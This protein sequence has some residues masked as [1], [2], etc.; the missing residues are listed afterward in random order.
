MFSS[1]VLLEPKKGEVFLK[2]D[3]EM[4]GCNHT[5]MKNCVL[6]QYAGDDVHCPNICAGLRH[7]TSNDSNPYV[8]SGME[9]G[10]RKEYLSLKRI[11]K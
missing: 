8:W 1:I 5:W 3:Y 11:G 2:H 4:T 6:T 9:S 10:V 7:C